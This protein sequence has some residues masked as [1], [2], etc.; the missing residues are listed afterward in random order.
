M[1]LTGR[2][3]ASGRTQP[4]PQS[5]SSSPPQESAKQYQADTKISK[6][7]AT[8]SEAFTRLQGTKKLAKV[9]SQ[10]R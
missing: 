10:V 9:V 2:Q 6:E 1:I 3:W 7:I 5:Q 4:R 8:L